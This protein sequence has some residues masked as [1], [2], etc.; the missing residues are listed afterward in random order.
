MSLVYGEPWDT[1]HKGTSLTAALNVV[2]LQLAPYPAVVYSILRAD[3]PIS[4]DD[5]SNQLIFN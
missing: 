3:Y 1:P 2:I 5:Q 4:M